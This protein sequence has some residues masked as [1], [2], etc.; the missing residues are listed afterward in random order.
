M[1]RRVGLGHQDREITTDHLVDRVAPESLAV[2]VARE[3]LAI[4]IGCDD[5]SLI[6]ELLDHTNIKCLIGTLVHLLDPERYNNDDDDEDD[7]DNVL[8]GKIFVGS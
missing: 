7:E 2:V 5:A 4:V 3:N 6:F 1:Q 8:G